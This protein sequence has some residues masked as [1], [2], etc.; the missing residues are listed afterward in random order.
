MQRAFDTLHNLMDQLRNNPDDI[1]DDDL[2]TLAGIAA[3][4]ELTINHLRRVRRERP[5]TVR[6]MMNF[7]VAEMAP[8]PSKKE[9]SIVKRNTLLP[10][11]VEAG[12][13]RRAQ[14]KCELCGAEF[15]LGI[16]HIMPRAAG[17]LDHEDNLALLCHTCHDEVEDEAIVSRAELL[18]Y[19]RQSGQPA[20]EVQQDRAAKAAATRAMNLAAEVREDRELTEWDRWT[21]MTQYA[22]PWLTLEEAI[23]FKRP[24]KA[25][26]VTVYGAGRHAHIT[27]E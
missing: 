20:A 23:A 12:V 19:K 13:R 22:V 26:H 14:G 15:R 17:G 10:G 27:P 6:A 7:I 16:H 18:R 4:L 9:E 2:A 24:E 8:P 3:D 21:T 1:T 5:A 11:G 25:W